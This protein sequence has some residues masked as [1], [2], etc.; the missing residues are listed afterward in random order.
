MFQSYFIQPFIEVLQVLAYMCNDN[1][2]LAIILITLI[3][4]LVL[5]PLM[6]SSYKTTQNTREKMDSLKPQM[7]EIQERMKNAKEKEEKKKIQEEMV[8]LYQ[9]HQVNPVKMGCLPMVIQM[10]IFIGLYY[11]IKGSEEIS[12][13]SFLWFNL[14]EV[15]I[16]IALIAAGLYGIQSRVTFIDAPPEQYRTMRWMG[17]ISPLMIG[18]LAM[19]APSALAL[20]W[21]V[22]ALFLIGQTY[23]SKKMY[24][25]TI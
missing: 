18:V 20:Y 3:V 23:L 8:S 1:Y 9:K 12:T 11:A 24:P 6:L 21:A 14:G 15:D 5:L 17:V 2:G 22:G 4:R 16:I 13:H 19:N 7:S 25:R 10:P